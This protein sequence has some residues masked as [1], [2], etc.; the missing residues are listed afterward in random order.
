MKLTT[1]QI[2][3]L[4]SKIYGEIRIEVINFNESLKTREAFKKW[5]AKNPKYRKLL[6]AAVEACNNA[7][8]SRN[9]RNNCGYNLRNVGDYKVKDINDI[10]RSIFENSLKLKYY[11]SS[12]TL[13]NDIILRTIEC[14]NLESII[15]TIKKK[16]I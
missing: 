1:Q 12:D 11:P 6:D 10:I 14:D 7:V 8:S 13:K 16:Y 9:I 3:A 2:N 5:E 4:T 15:E